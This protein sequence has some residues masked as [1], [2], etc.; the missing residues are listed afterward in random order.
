MPL[1]GDLRKNPVMRVN[2]GSAYAVVAS[3][4]GS[5]EQPQWH[6]LKADPDAVELKDGPEPFDGSRPRTERGRAT[7]VVAL[8][9]G[10]L[11]LPL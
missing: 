6:N 1:S 7:G 2:D 5:D 8:R 10:G 11:P 4:S 9:A 3:K